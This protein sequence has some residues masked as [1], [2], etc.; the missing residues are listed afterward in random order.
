MADFD[1]PDVIG[2][3]TAEAFQTLNGA[4]YQTAHFWSYSS[5]DELHV[6]VD[7]NPRGGA[8]IAPPALVTVWMGAE[9]PDPKEPFKPPVTLKQ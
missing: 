1:V 4:G 7:Q 9:P 2:M 6:I 5:F 3:G 8:P